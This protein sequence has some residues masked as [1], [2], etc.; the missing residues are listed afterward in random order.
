MKFKRFDESVNVLE[1][2]KIPFDY[3]LAIADFEKMHHNQI[4]HLCY[5]ALDIFKKENEMRMPKVW[6]VEDAIKFINIAK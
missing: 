2:S 5:L 3:N 1:E 4:S 6:N